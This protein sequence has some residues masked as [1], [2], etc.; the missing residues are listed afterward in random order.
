MVWALPWRLFS[1][2][3]NK[4]RHGNAPKQSCGKQPFRASAWHTLPAI[5]KRKRGQFPSPAPL[6]SS[7]F[8]CARMKLNMSNSTNTFVSMWTES[9]GTSDVGPWPRAFL[10]RGA[11]RCCFRRRVVASNPSYFSLFV[12]F[13]L[14]FAWCCC[15]FSRCDLLRATACCCLSVRV[16]AFA[17]VRDRRP[18]R[19]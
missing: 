15:C 3:A 17:W 19:D 11:H 18:E 1:P 5:L 16:F 7:Y 2:G 12:R 6:T 13:F 10:T 8:Q 4:T 14:S 9:I